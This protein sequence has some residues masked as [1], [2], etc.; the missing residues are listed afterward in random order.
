M[1]RAIVTR[2]F[3]ATD[4]KKGVSRRIEPSDK[5]QTLPAW[6]VDIGVNAGAAERVEPNAAGA[7]EQK[8]D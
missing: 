3:D 1:A 6:V 2:R 8:G 4:A 5:P 7:A